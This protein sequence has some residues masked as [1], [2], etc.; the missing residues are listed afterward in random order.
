MARKNNT[1]GSGLL[2][3]D[4]GSTISTGEI[5]AKL[6]DLSDKLDAIVAAAGIEVTVADGADAALGAIADA[7][8]AAGAVGSVSAKMRRLTTDLGALL[9]AFNSEDFATQTT[10]AAL[11]AKVIAAPAT[12]AKQDTLIAK[13]FATETTSALAKSVLD[14]IAGHDFATQTTLGSLLAKFASGT[15]IG[16][17]NISQ[18]TPGTTNG[19]VINSTAVTAITFHDA[20]TVAAR[21]TVLTVGGLK[22]LFVE[23]SG[24]SASRTI[25]FEGAGASATYSAITGVRLADLAVATFTITSAE[26]WQFDVSGLVTV[27][28]NLTAVAGGNVTITGR[29]VA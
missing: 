21:G 11:L 22:A 24:T 2:E 9:T 1:P 12:E 14:T 13:D 18:A 15:V 26:I 8:V 7:L 17:V 25:A 4:S 3:L 16:D 20:A 27:S 28:M 29:A 23:I 6:E 10:L 19:V 5:W